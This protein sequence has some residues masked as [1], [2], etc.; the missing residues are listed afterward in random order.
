SFEFHS[1]AVKTIEVELYRI[2]C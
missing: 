1:K 2:S